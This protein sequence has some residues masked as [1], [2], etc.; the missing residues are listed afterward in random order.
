M[1]KTHVVALREVLARVRRRWLAARWIKGGAQVLA[2]VCVVLLSIL[3]LEL[4]LVP[5]D[6]II[7][8]VVGVALVGLI[9]FAVRV[10]W[11]LRERP[12]DRRV[13]RFVEERCPELADSVVSA[14]EVDASSTPTEFADL[15]LD[16]SVRRLRAFDV[17]RVVPSAV[18]RRAGAWGGFA[19]VGVIVV[20]AWGFEPLAQITRTAWFHAL[21]GT[22]T[23]DVDPGDVRIMAGQPVRVRA[24]LRGVGQE[25][26]RT[27]PTLS[28]L[29]GENPRSIVMRETIDGYVSEFSEVHDSFTYRIRAG[30]RISS[31]YRVRALNP[32]QIERIDIEYT[33]PSFTGFPVRLE[34]DG[35]DVFA[36]AGTQVRALVYADTSI[37]AGALVLGNGRRVVLEP[38]G[39]GVRAATFVVEADDVYTV[40]I[41]DTD[42]LTT[43]DRSEYLI[44][45]THDRPPVVEVLRPV[46]D[47]E[48]TPLEEVTI[49]ARADDDYRVE[50]L[51]LVYT[52]AGRSEQVVP[53]QIAAPGASV[54]GV[55]TMF[56]E[57]LA[58][59]PGDVIT[60]FAQVRAVGRAGQASQARSDLFFLEVRPFDQE[61]EEAQSHS[62]LG[63]DAAEIQNLAA[64]QKQI[65]VATWRLEQSAD[66][67]SAADDTQVVAAAQAELRNTTAA[68]SERMSSRGRGRR[69]GDQGLPPERVA[70]RAAVDAMS[71]AVTALEALD[72]SAAIPSEVE[73]LNQ[74]LTAEATVRR[75]QV[76][77]E[78]GQGGRSAG[79]QAQQDLSALFDRELR[80]DQKTNFETTSRPDQGAR[81]RGESEVLARL[82]EL[83]RRQ[84][85]LEAALADEV[86]AEETAEERRRALARLMREQQE[87]REQLEELASRMNRGQQTGDQAASEGSQSGTPQSAGEAV[88]RIAD[89]MRRVLSGLRREDA[90]AARQG[91]G[92]ALGEMRQL[93]QQLQGGPG[94][95]TGAQA[96][97]R[98]LAEEL[99]AAQALRRRLSELQDASSQRDG[100]G[101]ASGAGG[102]RAGAELE[103]ENEASSRSQEAVASGQAAAGGQPAEGESRDSAVEARNGEGERDDV[104]GAPGGQRA[105]AQRELVQGLDAQPELLEA[106]RRQNPE[107]D[108]ELEAWANY[109]RSSSAPGT[110]AARQDFAGWVSL[111]RNLLLALEWLEL[112]RAERLAA[113]AR[114]DRVS[115][116]ADETDALPAEYRRLVGDYYR[117]LASGSPRS[118]LPGR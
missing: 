56:V 87:L 34:E 8:V 12:P 58:V 74:L 88:E 3:A 32:P 68:A 75:K 65:I 24:R 61:F 25:G 102:E 2:S 10:L 17:R 115:A 38:L 26:L 31:D 48:I 59:N 23:I 77:L 110:D 66:A 11:P 49:E 108:R 30:R 73:A 29:G 51:D 28:V 19:V 112:D 114:A 95:D 42:G 78:Q 4:A 1:T 117:S 116:G 43:R 35:G 72:T 6:L 105:D 13:A 98:Q 80:R 16:E 101:G 76:R 71:A 40:T 64:V 53:F 27:A 37:E 21:P 103:R 41:T 22:M 60:Y 113:L 104:G 86:G 70:M 52:V 57:D 55:R 18:L 15:V 47:R 82:R 7:L 81:E 111:Q 33:Y 109:W 100:Q 44:R 85:E 20:V 36:P 39:V 67:E 54:A 91:A 62:G 106:L 14:V 94:S 90:E 84:A 93:E 50:A 99:S 63:Q 9:G 83:A 92:D 79:G 89:Q 69:L 118:G 107:L 97:R 96:Q 45:V 46:G 5:S